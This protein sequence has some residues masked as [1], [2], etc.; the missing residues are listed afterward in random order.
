MPRASEKAA[1]RYRAMAR[2]AK[3][4]RG[5]LKRLR[6]ERR[7]K[8]EAAAPPS[9]AAAKPPPGQSIKQARGTLPF[10]AVGRLV[11]LYGQASASGLTRKGIVIET[12]AGAQVGAPHGGRVVFAGRFRGYGQL[13]I[14][15][16]GEGYHS[17]LAGLARI[18]NTIGQLV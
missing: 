10:P 2:Q 8:E 13:L 15:E 3:T 11:G 12:R 6:A 9:P 14:I 18:D 1:R 5:L 16:H 4:L 17:L 7:G